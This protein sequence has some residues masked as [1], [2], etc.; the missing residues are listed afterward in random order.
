MSSSRNL[1]MRINMKTILRRRKRM[2]A[3]LTM[4]IAKSTFQRERINTCEKSAWSNN[5]NNS[6][7]SIQSGVVTINWTSW[8]KILHLGS[9]SNKPSK[10]QSKSSAKQPCANS[11]PILP[12]HTGSS[13]LNTLL[14]NCP[15]SPA[16]T[17]TPHPALALTAALVLPVSKNSNTLY[18]K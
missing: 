16:T 15:V 7:L 14:S 5:D 11:T 10:T 13:H 3:L 4:T 18:G 1:I 6:R 12:S 2:R 9:R 8:L 17:S